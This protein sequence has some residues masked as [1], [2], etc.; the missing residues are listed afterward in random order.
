MFEFGDAYDLVILLLTYCLD[1]AVNRCTKRRIHY[2]HIVMIRFLI[3]YLISTTEFY[4][5]KVSYG[6]WEYEFESWKQGNFFT[7]QMDWS[8][9]GLRSP[10][11]TKITIAFFIFFLPWGF[12]LVIFSFV[13]CHGCCFHSAFIRCTSADVSIPMF[14]MICVGNV[15]MLGSDILLLLYTTFIGLE[16]DE[17]ER[18]IDFSDFENTVRSVLFF[19]SIFD[20]LQ[21]LFGLI[22]IFVRRGIIMKRL[23]KLPGCICCRYTYL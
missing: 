21:G 14:V 17:N 11:F 16:Y 22:W 2:L 7:L 15:L 1:K 3:S 13:L 8:Y 19:L 10:T 23:T 5:I 4:I 18:V 12:F 9:G 6:L 20:I